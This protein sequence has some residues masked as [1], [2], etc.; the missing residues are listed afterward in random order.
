MNRHWLAVAALFFTAAAWGATFPLIKNVLRYIAPEP[1]IF[2][3]F[4][5][6]GL[7]LMAVAARGRVLSRAM[8]R[9]GLLLGVLVFAGYWLQTRGLMTITASRSAFLTGLYVVIVP[10]FDGLVYGMR[11]PRRAWAASVL[12]V[13][14]TAVLIGGFD[15]RPNLGDLLTLICAAVFALH[16]VLS[17]RYSAAHSPTAIAAVQV[18][19]VGVLA[20]PPSL[21][22]P[23]MPMTAEVA[24]VI[25]S[26]A[27]VTT[28]L[29]FAALMWGQ[30]RVT[31]TEAAVILSFEPVAASI[32]AVVWDR[33]PITTA[34]ICGAVLILAAMVI[35]QLADATMSLDAAHSRHQ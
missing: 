29:A 31:A 34:F 15:A 5:L 9:P 22:A 30:S 1:F 7:I 21:F 13:I 20:A 16:V 14:G 3:R 26:T 8:V 11:I 19:F 27:V 10:F 12:A 2:W 23:R 17:A 33:E 28:A 24:I 25:I 35:S 6:A 4:T 32:T 18:L